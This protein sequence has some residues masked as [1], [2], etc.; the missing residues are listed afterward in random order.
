[1][2]VREHQ[3]QFSSATENRMGFRTSRWMTEKRR[4]GHEADDAGRG[5]A[6][7]DPGSMV[8]DSTPELRREA[9]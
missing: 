8:D 4:A 7:R 6:E 9:D 3:Q 5:G 1:M 2:Q